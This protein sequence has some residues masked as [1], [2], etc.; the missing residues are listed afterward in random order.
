M[1]SRHINNHVA[2]IFFPSSTRN[3]KISVLFFLFITIETYD[4]IIIKKKPIK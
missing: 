4:I 1:I 3:L 2:L